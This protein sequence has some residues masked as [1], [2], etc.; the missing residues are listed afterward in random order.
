MPEIKEIKLTGDFSLRVTYNDGESADVNLRRSWENSG[1]VDNFE[2][3]YIDSVTGDL[4]WP[5]GVTI[6][7]DALYRQVQLKGLMDRL[8]L[9]DQL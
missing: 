9:S 8:K 3:V 5:D 2:K 1:G 7:K 4:A 6:C